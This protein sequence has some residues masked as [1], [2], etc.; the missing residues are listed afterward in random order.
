MQAQQ[1]TDSTPSMMS[2]LLN[3]FTSPHEAF[4]RISTSPSKASSWLF[5]F[6]AAFAIS[7]LIAYLLVANEAL[8]AQMIDQQAQAVQKMV[9]SGRMTQQ[10]ADA[11]IDRMETMGGGMFI[12]FGILG[13]LVFLCIYY[14]GG[15]LFLW[16]AGKLALKSTA[17][18]GKYLEVYG[19]S[20]WVGVLGAIITVLLMVGLSS[21]Y[22][23]P[24][25]ALAILSE[26]DASNNMHKVLSSLNLFSVWQASVVGIG[27]SKL[28]GKPLRMSLG[29]SFGLWV[30]WVVV[31]VLLGI[32]R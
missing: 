20:A 29:V 26:Y 4:E 10:Q 9:E 8:R 15:S 2:K 5:P 18:Y 31:S 28:T 32:A 3:I 1:P 24:S 25:A 19:M 14:F 13:A 23:S 16:L 21:L 30:V 6:L 12:T 17:G 11:S 27:L 7:V 22:A